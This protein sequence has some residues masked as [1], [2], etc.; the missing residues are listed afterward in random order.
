MSAKHKLNAAYVNGA[1]IIAA[2]AGMATGSVGV[3]LLVAIV[4]I[5]GGMQ[6]GSIR[7]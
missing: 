4:L 6:D 1:L 2:I 5:I 7:K 3:F